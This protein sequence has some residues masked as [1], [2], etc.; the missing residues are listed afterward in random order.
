M[1]LLVCVVTEE[2]KFTYI[3]N[4]GFFYACNTLCITYHDVVLRILDASLM[5]F[6]LASSKVWNTR[7]SEERLHSSSLGVRF[8]V[9][10]IVEVVLQ[11]R[12]LMPCA[13]LC[14]PVCSGNAEVMGFKVSSFT[15]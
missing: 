14:V 2:P 7:S 11:G 9:L 10:L 6:M 5:H 4:Q 8:A 1:D 15:V 12:V 13:T 3:L